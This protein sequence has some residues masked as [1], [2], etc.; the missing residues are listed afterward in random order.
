MA[1]IDKLGRIARLLGI[2]GVSLGTL[3][4]SACNG[5]TELDGDSDTEEGVED[6]RQDEASTDGAE[7]VRQEDIRSEEAQDLTDEG[8]DTDLWE[9][10]C[11]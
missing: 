8:P 2:V 3:V 7:D 11:E 5:K 6:V 10:I 1:L 9:V 4:I